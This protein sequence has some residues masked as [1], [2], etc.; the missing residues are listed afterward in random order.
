MLLMGA[1]QVSAQHWT[2]SLSLSVSFD[3]FPAPTQ[4]FG[5]GR[6]SYGGMLTVGIRN[7][8]YPQVAAGVGF[9]D[10]ESADMVRYRCN[11]SPYFKVGM[12][13]NFRYA[14]GKPDFYGAFMRLGYSHAN[15][16][17]RNLYYTDGYW[18]E[19]GPLTLDGLDSNSVWLEVGGFI[20][21]QVMEHLSLG[22]DLSFAPFLHKGKTPVGEPYFVPGYGTTTSML[23]F[24]FNVYFDL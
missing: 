7:R 2:D 23:C 19:Q 15:A 10:T 11:L 13:Y 16:S 12:A 18:P 20:K 5:S 22:W 9:A 4:I 24:A 21:V 3:A 8:F 17:V 14:D 1:G 6:A